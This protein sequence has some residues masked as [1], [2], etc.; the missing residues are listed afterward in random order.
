MVVLLVL[1][2]GP[3]R[4]HPPVFVVEAPDPADEF[5]AGQPPAKRREDEIAAGAPQPRPG[6]SAEEDEDYRDA[7]PPDHEPIDKRSR[8]GAVTAVGIIAIVFGC[9][10]LL[11]AICTA[12]TPT[13]SRSMLDLAA[14][15]NPNDPNVAKQKQIID[16]VPAWYFILMGGIEFLR[17]VGLIVGGVG[18]LKRVNA[19]RWLIMVLACIGVLLV[20]VGTLGNFALGT[21]N[22]DDPASL[23]GGV[24]GLAFSGLLNVGFAAMA[25]FVLLNAKN[26]A[27]FR[28]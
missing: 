24:C 7:E 19:G 21:M 26:A 17:G 1:G 2:C 13:F 22:F 27:E 20:I 12:G 25:L 11:G 28:S 4:G 16:S 3:Y 8:S 10:A 23:A 6:M 9:F 14:K 5:E 18:V 15:A